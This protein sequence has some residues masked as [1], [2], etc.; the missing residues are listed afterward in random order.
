MKK[1]ENES[2]L[3]ELYKLSDIDLLRY[4]KRE[5]QSIAFYPLSKRLFTKK[6]YKEA[7]QILRNGIKKYPDYIEPKILLAK[8]YMKI[9]NDVEAVQS[10]RETIKFAPECAD[11][12]YY[13]SEIL[14]KKG[15]K[16]RAEILLTKA[17]EIAPHSPD[18]KNAF[19]KRFKNAGNT[20]TANF[21]IESTVIESIDDIK[22]R[23]LKEL[24]ERGDDYQK[25]QLKNKEPLETDI[26]DE[27]E[28]EFSYKKRQNLLI[29]IGLLIIVAV[30]AYLIFI[31]FNNN[32]K[33]KEEKNE[34]QLLMI[35]NNNVENIKKEI[36][37][38]SPDITLYY[39]LLYHYQIDSNKYKDSV[40]KV[41]ELKKLN[42]SWKYLSKM[43]YYLY[44][45]NKKFEDLYEKAKIKFKN[46]P[47]V[48]LL[49]GYRLLKNDDILNSQSL[50]DL[51]YKKSNGANRF[52]TE[53]ASLYLNR[54]AISELNSLNIKP[55][56]F[57]TRLFYELLRKSSFKDQESVLLDNLN[58]TNNNIQKEKIAI[59]L[60]NLYI[61]KGMLKKA[62][63]ILN[64]ELGNNKIPYYQ[65]LYKHIHE[66]I[67]KMKQ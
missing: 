48:F 43:T 40:T 47:D 34:T 39:K 56:S 50:F 32:Q 29:V 38:N 14:F 12:Y 21:N 44:T 27:L 6:K 15:I 9:D 53:L 16:E 41:K 62:V 10:L 57:E 1:I 25:E 13:L 52:K 35:L 8:L 37:N 3:K 23:A 11:S 36:P 24:D 7:I 30:I 67:K 64:K 18:I 33:Q 51:A 55:T 22:K 28:K 19:E 58:S 31:I 17:Y 2:K 46:Y 66:K 42:N 20:T 60:I 65:E 26:L 49:K 61:R 63:N 5:P 45:N 54:G 59:Y 4:F